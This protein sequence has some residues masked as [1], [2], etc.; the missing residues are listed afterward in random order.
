MT[1]P[2][3]D[4]Y[5]LPPHVLSP[6]AGLRDILYVED[7]AALARLLQRRMDRIGL[8]VDLAGDAEAGLQKL[9]ERAYDLVLV[10]YNLPGMS[11]LDLLDRMSELPLTPPAVILTVG[12]DE[13]IALAALEQGAADYAVKDVNQTYLDLL[14]AI[15]VAAF[16]KERLLR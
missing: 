10:D 5:A 13:R 2:P 3:P 7:D 8:R 11:G 12:G 16:T 6:H 4:P 15:M 1:S 9:H 14:P